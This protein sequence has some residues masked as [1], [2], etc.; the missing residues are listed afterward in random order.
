MLEARNLTKIYRGLPAIESINFTIRPGEVVGY[1]GPN[2]SGKSTTVKIITG[3]VQPTEGGVF[4]QFK[5]RKVK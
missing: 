5:P 3:L 4:F 2:G 1:L